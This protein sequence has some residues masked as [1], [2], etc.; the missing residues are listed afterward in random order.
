MGIKGLNVWIGQNF[1][2]VMVP[3]HGQNSIPYDHIAF[4]LNGI[5]HTACRKNG[6][7]QTVIKN[8]L[9]ELDSLLRLFPAA[10]TVFI[11]LDGPGPTAKLME[12]RKRR[13]D[14][15]LKAIDRAAVA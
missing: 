3:V 8:V 5:V 12:Q 4:D 14:K 10:K 7:E 1:P 2:G 11:A 6:T 9:M 13:I 15:V